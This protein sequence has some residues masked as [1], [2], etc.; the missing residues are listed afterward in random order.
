MTL[1]HHNMIFMRVILSIKCV[2]RPHSARNGI[3]VID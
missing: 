3:Y 2:V 1:E